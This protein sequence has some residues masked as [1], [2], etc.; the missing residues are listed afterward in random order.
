MLFMDVLAYFA[1]LTSLTLAPGPLSALLVAKTLSGDRSGAMIFGSGIA[2]GDSLIILVVCSGMGTWL[3]S[4]PVIFT[5]G[6]SLAVIYILWIALWMLKKNKRPNPVETPATRK[7]LAELGSGMV[8]CIASPQTLLLY[9][10]LVPR[11][12]DLNNIS[13]TPFLVLLFTTA[14]ALCVSVFVLIYLAQTIRT[15]VEPRPERAIGDWILAA[16]VA[17]SGLFIIS[18]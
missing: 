14:A 16:V 6:K 10:I 18:M 12:I 2:L 9:L 11:L 7:V 1:V 4:T 17:G 15:W 5:I 3:E 8:T 13:V